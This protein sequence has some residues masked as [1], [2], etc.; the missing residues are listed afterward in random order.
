MKNVISFVFIAFLSL[1]VFAQSTW[2]SDKNHSQVS[3][4]IV[5]SGISEVEGVFDVFDATIVT[6]EEDF[7][8]AQF[9]VDID[10]ASIDTQVEMRDNHLKSADFFDVEKYPTMTFKSTSIEEI[11][12]NKYKVRGDLTLHGITKPVTLDVWYRGTNETPKGSTAGFQITG[13]ILRSDFNL[14]PDFPEPALSNEVKLKVDAEF[15]KQ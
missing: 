14:G 6:S 8:D 5:H 4:A 1:S 10:V 12:D 7:S 13:T 9:E 2:N 3:F 11:S 15:K